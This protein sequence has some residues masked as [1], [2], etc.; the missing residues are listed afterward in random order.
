[1]SV[2][3]L[4]GA[5]GAPTLPAALAEAFPVEAAPGV[6]LVAYELI[7]APD[8]APAVLF[9]HANGFNAGC[10][11]PFL[12]ILGGQLKLF[13]YDARGHGASA[14]LPPETPGAYD[15]DRFAQDQAAVIE[16]VRGRIGARS[17]HFVSHSFGGLA[18][19]ILAGRFGVAPW[20]TMT[21]FEPPIYPPHGHIHRDVAEEDLPIFVAWA[22]R[23]QERWS[24]PA[25]YRDAMARHPAFSRFSPEMIEVYAQAALAPEQGDGYVLRCPGA[26]E[27]LVYA[28]CP[29]SNGFDVLGEVPIPTLVLGSDP[30]RHRGRGFFN[31]PAEVTQDVADALPHGSHRTMTGL[32]H[33]MVLEDPDA[34]AEVALEHIV[35]DG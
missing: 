26:V 11:V 30:G 29:A 19:V 12:E 14:L 27:S 16:A 10:Y 15:L 21:L 1:L 35:A 5:R 3:P 22:K 17:L 31:W 33:L 32:G 7:E 4:E 6:T 25:E 9:A 24:S 34:C 28:G 20:R 23:R 2:S 8:E 18:A 13:A